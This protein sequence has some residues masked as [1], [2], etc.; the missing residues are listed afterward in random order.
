M[1]TGPHQ[2]AFPRPC[3]NATS[4]E[5]NLEQEGM[6]YREWLA[7]QNMAAMVGALVAHAT[8]ERFEDRL[9]KVA[10]VAFMAADALIAEGRK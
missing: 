5:R 1:K 2:A 7:G 8:W 6:S 3:G 4:E 9:E 10:I